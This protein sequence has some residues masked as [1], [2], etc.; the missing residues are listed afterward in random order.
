M[1]GLLPPDSNLQDTRGG[2][3]GGQSSPE[4]MAG[5][6]GAEGRKPVQRSTWEPSQTHVPT[7]SLN[8]ELSLLLGHQGEAASM[9]RR[10]LMAKNGADLKNRQFGP[11][12]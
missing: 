3:M 11:K 6:G 9:G 12:G 8:P 4:N 5:T 7:P 2:H 10:P 1:A